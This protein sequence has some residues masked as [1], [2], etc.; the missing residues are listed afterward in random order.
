MVLARMFLEYQGALRNQIVVPLDA[1]IDLFRTV[2]SHAEEMGDQ[3]TLHRTDLALFDL[4]LDLDLDLAKRTV[5]CNLVEVKCCAR[6]LGLS[7][8]GQLKERITQQINQ[9]ERILQRHF[10]PHLTT[11]DRPDRLLMTR[12]LATLLDFYLARGI[13]Y[14]L[15]GS[16]AGEEARAL[17]DRLED[18]YRLQ[19]S[20]SGLGSIIEMW[21]ESTSTSP[22]RN[23][24]S[25]R[26]ISSSIGLEWI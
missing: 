9:S 7:G 23:L 6:R 24:R 13:R 10:D 4:D 8:Y 16:D 1:H 15:I 26:W 17:L 5:S 25:T 11:P 3:V 22:E 2:Q 12:E 19:F 14:R 21:K 20:R 18:G